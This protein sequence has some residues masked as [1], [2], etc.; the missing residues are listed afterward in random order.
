MP[1]FDWRLSNEEVAELATFVRKAWGNDS[2]K[3]SP[4]EVATLRQN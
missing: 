3:V 2:G 4:D 1:G